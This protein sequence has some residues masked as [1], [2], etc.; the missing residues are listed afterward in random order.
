M[1]GEVRAIETAELQQQWAVRASAPGWLCVS[2]AVFPGWRAQVDGVDAPIEPAFF[3][4]RAV[5]VPA[6]ESVVSFRYEPESVRWGLALTAIGVLALGLA[7]W[8]AARRPA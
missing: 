6:G 5:R 4:M 8:R 3:G 7:A 2:D 1:E